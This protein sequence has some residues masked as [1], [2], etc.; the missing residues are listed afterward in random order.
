MFP[1]RRA[2]PQAKQDGFLC[3]LMQDMRP[4]LLG[5]SLTRHNSKTADKSSCCAIWNDLGEVCIQLCCAC[6][7]TERGCPQVLRP[8]ARPQGAPPLVCSTQSPWAGQL[9]RGP[10][11][12]IC[13]R[14]GDSDFKDH[15]STHPASRPSQHAPPPARSVR[16][17]RAGPRG[18]D[19]RQ[20][21]CWM[22]LSLQVWAP[23]GKEGQLSMP[24]A[25]TEWVRERERSER[26]NRQ[27]DG[28]TGGGTTDWIPP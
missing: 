3:L 18:V 20:L 21:S 6:R 19:R 11:S 16:V 25:G 24:W 12:Y 13:P 4:S 27:M 5:I 17:P 23:S 10:S 7:C 26:A 14:G 15:T 2:R 8:C 28:W 9:K 22:C 1:G